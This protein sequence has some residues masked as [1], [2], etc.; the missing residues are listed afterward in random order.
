MS[1]DYGFAY[2]WEGNNT[3]GEGGAQVGTL[4]EL[5][6]LDGEFTV[7]ELFRITGD[8]PHTSGGFIGSFSPVGGGLAVVL[9]DRVYSTVALTPGDF[10]NPLPTALPF[11]LLAGTLV[12]TPNGERPVEEIGRGDEILTADGEIAQVRW[13]GKQAH[14]SLFNRQALP[15][16]ISAGAL[17]DNVP[18]RDLCVSPD[19]AILIDGVLVQAQAL[20]NGMTITVMA[21]PPSRIDYYHLELDRQRIIVADGAPVE[22]FVDNVSRAGFDNFEEWVSLGLESQPAE[23]LPYPRVKSARQLRVAQLV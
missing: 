1:W 23:A 20:V 21:D 7:G 4:S 5:E 13:V 2:E 19:H 6:T 9:D 14:I 12:L 11:C 10:Y 18:S 3:V 22:S 17:G 16:V 15:V 8:A